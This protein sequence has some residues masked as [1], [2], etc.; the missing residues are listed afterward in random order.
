[1][2]GLF[3]SPGIRCR[4]ILQQVQDERKWTAF[5]FPPESAAGPSFNKFRMSGLDDHLSRTRRPHSA[6][7]ELAAAPIPLILN[8]LKDERNEGQDG[9]STSSG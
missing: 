6:H 7:P 9:P 8:L 1:M 5:F 4:A 2:D 3:L